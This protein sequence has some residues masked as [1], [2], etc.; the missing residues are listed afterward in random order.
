MCENSNEDDIQRFNTYSAPAKSLT[1]A[2]VSMFGRP[3]IL[4]IKISFHWDF[5]EGPIDCGPPQPNFIEDPDTR[6]L[7]GTTPLISNKKAYME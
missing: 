3:T 4:Y 7:T 5:H 2:F 6:T 1:I